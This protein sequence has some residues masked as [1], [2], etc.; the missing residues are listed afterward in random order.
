[1]SEYSMCMAC[2]AREWHVH[3]MLHGMC[4][5]C[6]MA[7]AWHVAWHVHVHVHGMCMAC[8]HLRID[9]AEVGCVAGEDAPRRRG[10][11]PAEWRVEQP[12][13]SGVV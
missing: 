12:S 6:C 8:A 7:C 2:M 4:M 13:H 9:H 3:G 11:V 1:M 5:A 10:V